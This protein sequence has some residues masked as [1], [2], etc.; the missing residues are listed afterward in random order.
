[1]YHACANAAANR[2]KGDDIT[3]HILGGCC[4][5]RSRKNRE[6]REVAE[7]GAQHIIPTEH[8]EKIYAKGSEELIGDRRLI[9]QEKRELLNYT[10]LEDT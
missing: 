6:G 5:K 9:L 10:M 3:R 8:P 7:G 2:E 4:G 1:L